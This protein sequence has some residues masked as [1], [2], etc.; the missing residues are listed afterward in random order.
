[1]RWVRILTVALVAAGVALAAAG[2]ATGRPEL[3]LAGLLM[4]WAGA[5]KVV[6]A[7]LWRRL[8]TDEAMRAPDG[9]YR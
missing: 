1:M 8:G 6:V 2:V 7:V 5:I 3:A 4:L 9:S